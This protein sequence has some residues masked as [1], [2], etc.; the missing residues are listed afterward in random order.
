MF[1]SGVIAASFVDPVIDTVQFTCGSDALIKTTAIGFSPSNLFTMGS[2]S[3]GTFVIG[4]GRVIDVTDGGSNT[5]GFATQLSDDFTSNTG[6]N[7]F[8]LAFFSKNAGAL[9]AATAANYFNR[10]IVTNI[11]DSDVTTHSFSDFTAGSIV[12]LNNDSRIQFQ[13]NIDLGWATNDV[14]KLEFRSD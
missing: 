13:K 5:G 3:T 12:T 10:V 8:T 14:I 6:A 2:I 1:S 11:T 9:P 7:R 4:S